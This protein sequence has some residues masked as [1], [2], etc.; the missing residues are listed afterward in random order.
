MLIPEVTPVFLA[1]LSELLSALYTDAELAL[2]DD[3]DRSDAGFE[4]QLNAVDEFVEKYQIPIVDTAMRSWVVT[5]IW[6]PECCSSI[7][8]SSTTS[9][10]LW[11]Y[12]Q[13]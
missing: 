6:F 2:N 9:G 12:R 4:A 5:V 1:D 7:C 11:S 8:A 10:M 3:W 13:R